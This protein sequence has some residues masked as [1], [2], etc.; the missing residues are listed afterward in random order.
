MHI[1]SGFSIS[2]PVEK[3]RRENHVC[4]QEKFKFRI[5]WNT[6][7]KQ[8][9]LSEDVELRILNLFV[10]YFKQKSMVLLC[11]PSNDTIL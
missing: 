4:I 6:S 5:R 10:S 8:I 1:L 2:N 9:N 11:A 3:R 7:K